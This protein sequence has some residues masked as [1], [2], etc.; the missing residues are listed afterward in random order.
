M[1]SDRGHVQTGRDEMRTDKSTALS[2]EDW[3]F[4]VFDKGSGRRRA[5]QPFASNKSAH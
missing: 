1:G 2:E 5:E 3:A 4:A